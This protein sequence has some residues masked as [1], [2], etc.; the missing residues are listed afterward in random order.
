MRRSEMPGLK[1]E[2][3]GNHGQR[4]DEESKR[5]AKVAGTFSDTTRVRI[6]ILL[7]NK[8]QSGGLTTM[9]IAAQLGVLQP[10]VS[11]HLAILLKYGL[12]S[13]AK[14]GRQRIYTLNSIKV[15]PILK[16]LAILSPPSY[17]KTFFSLPSS[18]STRKARPDL[19][20]RQCRTCY[21]HL[22]GI[23]GVELLDQILRAGWVR[24]VNQRPNGKAD[25]ILYR[26]SQS[27]LKSLRDRGVDVDQAMRSNRTFAY[28]CLDWTERRPHLGGSLGKAVLNSVLSRGIVMRMKETRALKLMKPISTWISI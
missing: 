20:I 27:G 7:M 10:R 15:N 14:R 16:D 6:M 12:I 23:A 21:D 13:V 8:K 1:R 22:A 25:R 9:N 11:S 26:L 28:G 17:S 18:K 24:K 19:A 5:I 4:M 3:I 2:T